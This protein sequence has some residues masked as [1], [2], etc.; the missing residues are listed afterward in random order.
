[1]PR[2]LPVTTGR[3]WSFGRRDCSQDAKNA[4]PSMCTMARGNE[5]RVSGS[6]SGVLTDHRTHHR[7]D[8]QLLLGMNRLEILIGCLQEHPASALAKIFDGPLPVHLGDD[9]IPIT[10]IQP[11]LDEQEVPGQDA[12]LDH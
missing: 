1:M 2:S 9:N 12:G 6:I 7:C 8:L 11:T 5:A 4:S 10:R 3:P